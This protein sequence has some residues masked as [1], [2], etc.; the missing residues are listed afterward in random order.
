MSNRC[1]H[2]IL[3]PSAWPLTF[4]CTHRLLRNVGVSFGFFYAFLRAK[5]ECFVRLCHHLGVCLS[6][7]PSVRLS[8]CHTRDLY[9]NGASQNHEI[10]TVGCPKVS[11]LSF[12]NFVPLGAGV[13]LERGRHRGIPLEKNVILPLLARI[14]WKR[15][16]IGTYMLLNITS[17]S[18]RLFW[19]YQHRWPWT[20]LNSLKRG[21]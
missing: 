2:F 10:F 6:V 15:L 16:Q 17:T 14:M 11:S 21:F 12:L 8:V 20:T 13:P 7:C 3:R 1:R 9:Q 19:I 4:E 5:A 18:D